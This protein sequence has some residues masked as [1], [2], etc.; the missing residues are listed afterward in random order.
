MFTA[1][2][3]LLKDEVTGSTRP[4]GTYVDSD[5]TIS[6]QF[7]TK[8]I[9]KRAVVSATTAAT[10]DVVISLGTTFPVVHSILPTWTPASQSLNTTEVVPQVVGTHV[11]ASGRVYEVKVRLTRSTGTG[12]TTNGTV[13]ITVTGT[14]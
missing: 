9:T 14:E 11:D 12:T 10:V 4:L 3:D 2:P 5:T 7:A 1:Y 8:S 13:S 6:R